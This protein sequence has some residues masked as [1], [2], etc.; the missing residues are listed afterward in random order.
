MNKRCIVALNANARSLAPKLESLSDCMDE[1]KADFSV[2]T[3]T[4]LQDS[5]AKNLMIDTAGQ[6]GLNTLVL[7]RQE[8]ADNGR[9]Y[10][11]VAVFGRKTT[12][13]LKLV[14]I[15]N[16]DSFEVLC[17]AGKVAK[18]K[19]K[20]VVVYIPPNYPKVR[21]DVCLEYVADVVSEA[22][23]RFESALITVAGNWNQWPVQHLLDEHPDLSEV[24]HGPTRGDR[25]IDRFLVNF[26]RSVLE[27]DVL[28]PLDDVM[29]RVSDHRIAYFKS[30][31]AITPVK[32]VTYRYRHFTD[33]G[34]L[35]FRTWVSSHDFAKVCEQA[36]VNLQLAAFLASME[37][38]MDEY[39][40]YKTTTRREKDPP[41][42]H[43]LGPW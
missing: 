9:Q 7:N 30:E 20:V 40:H 6:Y 43:T 31:F 10:G 16:P 4:W 17:V 25:K 14:E 2:V 41:W 22:K 3:E 28:P 12:T 37:R 23:R 21:A 5:A 27:S 1:I 24:D 35:K 26:G 36:D 18:I 42:I 32:K 34:A 13:N 11:G 33:E 15:S 8:I 39:F 29:G 19:E 38:K